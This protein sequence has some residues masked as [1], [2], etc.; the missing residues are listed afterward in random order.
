MP[1]TS[2]SINPRGIQITFTE[3]DHSYVTI[4]NGKTINYTSVT[5]IVGKYFPP[6]DPTGAI[7]ERCAKKEGISVEEMKER[8]AAKG[9]ESCRLGTRMHEVC[10]DIELGRELRNTAENPIEQKRL[11]NAIAIAKKFREHI[12]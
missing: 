12:D 7:T 6:F 3:A 1:A 5:S 4:L 8:W 10:E 9:R 2:K 11:D